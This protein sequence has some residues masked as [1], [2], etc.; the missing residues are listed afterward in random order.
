MLNH[1]PLPYRRRCCRRRSR[2]TP[3]MQLLRGSTSAA[4]QASGLCAL[5]CQ[6]ACKTLAR[7]WPKKPVC[8]QPGW[9]G[10]RMQLSAQ[11]FCHCFANC[12]RVPVHSEAV[13][14]DVCTRGK[15]ASALRP[16]GA[17]LAG[18]DGQYPLPLFSPHPHIHIANG[19]AATNAHR[20]LIHLPT[21]CPPSLPPP[22]PWRSSRWLA[23]RPRFRR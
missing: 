8:Q 3:K 5:V 7:H 15:L 17:L 16:L 18:F 9:W 4:W 20:R 23:W 6:A 21:C 12:C 2:T 13:D 1:C 19:P 14:A 10:A 22:L 11:M